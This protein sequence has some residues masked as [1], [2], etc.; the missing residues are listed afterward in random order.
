MSVFSFVTPDSLPP[1]NN[2]QVVNNDLLILWRVNEPSPN[3][4]YKLTVANAKLLFASGGGGGGAL[5][6]DEAFG[7][8]WNNDTVNAPSRNA[9]YDV[10][11]TL[12]PNGHTHVIN[13]VTGLSSAISAKQDASVI[14][15]Q[16]VDEYAAAPVGA[17][18]TKVNNGDISYQLPSG[19]GA[20]VNNGAYPT[21]WDNDTT[22]AP[23]RN[24]VFDIVST[25]AAEAHT[26]VIANVTGLQSALDAKAATSHTHVINDVTSLQASLDAKAAAS[27]THVINDVVNLQT[28]LDAKAATSHTHTIAN[29]TN[30]QTS[31]DAKQDTDTL[32]TQILTEYASAPIG[33]VPTKVTA[34]DLQYLVP[35]GSGGLPSWL[36]PVWRSDVVPTTRPDGSALQAGDQWWEVN[37]TAPFAPVY[38]FPWF[39][40]ESTNEWQSPLQRQDN[41]IVTVAASAQAQVL[42]ELST[43]VTAR[44]IKSVQVRGRANVVV[45]AGVNDVSL[46]LQTMA[47]ASPT[48]VVSALISSLTAIGANTANN[49]RVYRWNV[50]SANQ[51]QN[52][53]AGQ[54]VQMSIVRTVGTG[55][56]T[57]GFTTQYVWVR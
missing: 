39:W 12:A 35:S 52:P 28:S 31:L 29:V 19:G 18:P 27:H 24:A 22:N 1:I 43:T 9:V 25:L 57:L 16:I 4:F 37:N 53:A 49:N 5:V 23:S 42:S 45:T 50:P 2:T 44:R 46:T 40:D 26:H 48:N 54:F 21:G 47:S 32:L 10:I 20:S 3:K 30:L 33:A 15:Q 55:T 36:L 14:L 6:N 13:D 11:V 7:A 51:L 34:S 8:N 41:A 17:I 56:F 38:S